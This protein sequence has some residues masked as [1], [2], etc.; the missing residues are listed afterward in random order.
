MF[1]RVALFLLVAA[2]AVMAHPRPEEPEFIY[3]VNYRYSEVVCSENNNNNTTENSNASRDPDSGSGYGSGSANVT[4]TSVENNLDLVCRLQREDDDNAY[5]SL[6]A[7]NLVSVN[8]Q[9]ANL[10]SITINKYS[11]EEPLLI[12]TPDAPRDS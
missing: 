10:N 6:V 8:V 12:A 9:G 2:V 7:N 4:S 1:V 11:Q 3:R 5:A